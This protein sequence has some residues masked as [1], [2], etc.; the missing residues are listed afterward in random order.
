M[1]CNGIELNIGDIV[2]CPDILRD[3]IFEC[4]VDGFIVDETG[5]HPAERTWDGWEKI[6]AYHEDKWFKT[7]AEAVAWLAENVK[8]G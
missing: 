3:K 5:V 4:E 6:G 8:K 7:R 1:N 2:F